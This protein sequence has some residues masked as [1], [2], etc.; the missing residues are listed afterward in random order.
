MITSSV[1]RSPRRC[2]PGWGSRRRGRNR[3]P[4]CRSVPS[5]P[6]PPLPLPPLPLPLPPLAAAS[7]PPVPPWFPGEPVEQPTASPAAIAAARASGRIAG[8][9]DRAESRLMAFVASSSGAGRPDGPPPPPERL[10]PNAG[11]DRENRGRGRDCSAALPRRAP[12]ASPPVVR[13]AD[14][15]RPPVRTAERPL[16]RARSIASPRPIALGTGAAAG[17]GAPGSL[18]WTTPGRTAHDSRQR[19]GSWRRR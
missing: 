2:A 9:T 19:N 7:C 14:G 10:V 3:A 6:L 4:S 5:S 15:G 11:I 18:R 13:T 16:A 1:A 17:E 8:I 12:A